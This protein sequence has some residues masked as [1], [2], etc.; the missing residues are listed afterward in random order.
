M[1]AD[2]PPTAIL[3]SMRKYQEGAI[4]VSQRN[5]ETGSY[6]HTCTLHTAPGESAVDADFTA[7]VW[8]K[9][10][11]LRTACEDVTVEVNY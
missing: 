5:S 3:P 4:T 1:W 6:A 8:P 11:E 2:L 9:H 7:S 10:I